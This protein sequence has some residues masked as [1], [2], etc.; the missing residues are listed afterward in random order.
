MLSILDWINLDLDLDW[1]DLYLDLDWVDCH[2]QMVS[3][4]YPWEIFFIFFVFMMIS[5]VK[6]STVHHEQALSK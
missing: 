2:N 1:I 3:S 5:A 4:N 6:F